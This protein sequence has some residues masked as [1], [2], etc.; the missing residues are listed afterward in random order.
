MH[1]FRRTTSRWTSCAESC[2][3]TRLSTASR[4]WPPTPAPTPCPVL[5]TTCPSPR[6]CTARV[7]SNPP[8]PVH[9][10]ALSL[11]EPHPA[12][13]LSPLSCP[14]LVSRSASSGRAGTRVASSLPAREVTVYKII[15][16]KKEKKV[17]LKKVKKPKKT[18]YF[19][20][21]KV[22]FSPPDL[23][24]KEEELTICTEMFCFVVT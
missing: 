16:C 15:F 22:F 4:E 12:P 21:Q 8:R 1:C 10:P 5:W 14:G 17:T 6:R 19:I 11:C 7:T 23:N 9:A 2:R 3:R 13:P 20:I 18:T 24:G